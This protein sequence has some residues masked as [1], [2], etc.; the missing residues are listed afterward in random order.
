MGGERKIYGTFMRVDVLKI[1]KLGRA[2]NNGKRGD[3]GG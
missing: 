2:F 1:E 3:K